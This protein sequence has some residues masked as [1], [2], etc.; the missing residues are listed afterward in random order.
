MTPA[1]FEAQLRQDLTLQQLA[2]AIGQ[3][4]VIART[5][6]DRVLAMQMRSVKYME[7]RLAI[8][9][10]LDKVKLADGAAKKFYDENAKQFELPEQA[11]LNMSCCRWKPLVR[12]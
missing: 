7:Y 11:K 9:A 3:S 2:G 6:S 8:D 12:N 1:G 4:G 5:V 10:F